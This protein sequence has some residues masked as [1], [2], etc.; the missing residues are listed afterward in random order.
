MNFGTNT[1]GRA[2]PCGYSEHKSSV[3]LKDSSIESEWNS[4]YFKEIRRDFLNGKWPLNCRRCE[5]VEKMGGRSKK[6]ES[7][8]N[9]FADNERLVSM[10]QPDG[11]VPYYPPH[12]DIRVGTICN[13]KCIHCG[14]GASSKWQEDKYMLDKYPNTEKYDINNKWIEQD[15]YIWDSISENIDQTRKLSFLGGEPFANKQHNKFIDKISQTEYSKNISL[16]YVT[17]LTLLTEEMV[18]KFLKFKGVLLQVSIDAVETPAEYFRFPVKWDHYVSQLEMLKKYSSSDVLKVKFQWTCSNVS[19]F[20]LPQTYEFTKNYPNMQ[21]DFCNHVEWPIHMSAQNL[22]SEVK[23]VIQLKLISYSSKFTAAA[24]ARVGF[25][26]D[27][28]LAEDLWPKHGNTLMNY[29]DDLDYA[30][31]VSWRHSFKEMGLE[32]YAD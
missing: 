11:S 21:F 32:R 22:P 26:V 3:K 29:L 23:E 27:H 20:Y 9:L 5:Y 13:L 28:M 2:R 16:F 30:R 10:T 8:F 14:T 12:M 7:N 6:F 1:F 4:D 17:N 19:M 18:E 25:Y 15:S 31:S 24:W